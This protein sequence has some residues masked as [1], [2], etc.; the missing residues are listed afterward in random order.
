MIYELNEFIIKNSPGI[1]EIY[2]V[3]NGKRYVGQSIKLKQR[4]QRHLNELRRGTHKNKHLQSSWNKYGEE[5]FCFEPIEYCDISDLDSR[6]DY[7]IGLFNCNDRERGYNIRIDNKTNRGLKWSDEQ[8]EKMKEA[9]EKVPYF[10]NHTIPDWIVEKAHE[11]SRNK[12]WSDE[13]RKRHSILMTGL[14]V[15]DTSK[16]KLAQQGENNPSHKLCEC[17]VKEIRA[18]LKSCMYQSK[19]IAIAY[20][21]KSTN[22][23]AINV[24]RSWMNVSLN[25]SEYEQYLKN[26]IRKMERIYGNKHE[27][28]TISK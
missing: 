10:H 25:D 27:L 13:E 5:K 8:R 26:G 1:Y 11:A 24:G 6:E 3:V 28:G 14:K 22:I 15:N 23:S 19:D 7:Y 9:V 18:L 20:G 2:N 21:V 16:M 12:V 4:L 17:E